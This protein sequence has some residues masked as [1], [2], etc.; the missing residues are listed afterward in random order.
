MDGENGGY[1]P[2]AASLAE[3]VAS[4]WPGGG[5]PYVVCTG[6]EP[7]LQLDEVL[8]AAFHYK[9]LEIAVETNGTVAEPAGLD[10]VCV[11][12]KAGTE[13]LLKAGDEIKLVFPQP[14]AEP[15]Q[16]EQLDFKNWFLQPMD[17][18]YRERNTQLAVQYCLDHP[19][20]RLSL[21]THKMLGIP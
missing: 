17:G 12:P 8:V 19:K 20:W 9:G 13:L 14:G 16:Y 4:L 1:F 2:D 5:R 15:E 21:Q 18:P 6:G 7:L 3:K 11:S 10:W